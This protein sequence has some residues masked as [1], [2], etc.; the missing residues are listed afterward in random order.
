LPRPADLIDPNHLAEPA[1][2]TLPIRVRQSAALQKVD[3]PG[4][5]Q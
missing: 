4:M 1:R 3:N 5:V 2:N